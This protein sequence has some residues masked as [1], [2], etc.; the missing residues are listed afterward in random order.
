MYVHY[1]EL[2][3]SGA[4]KEF[5]ITSQ[6]LGSKMQNSFFKKKIRVLSAFFSI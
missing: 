3:L 6:V 5:S 1:N 2:K 4:L